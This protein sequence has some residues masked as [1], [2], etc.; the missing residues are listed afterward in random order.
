MNIQEIIKLLNQNLP[1]IL[2]TDTVYGLFIKKTAENA[3]TLYQIKN[4]DYSKKLVIYTNDWQYVNAPVTIVKHKQGYRY[5][6][7]LSEII[8]NVGE[9]WGTSANISN[10]Y[11]VTQVSQ[12]KLKLPVYEYD[13]LCL[14][15]EST[16]FNIDTNEIYRQGLYFI[17]TDFYTL[18]NQQSEIT[19]SF[20]RNYYSYK[21]NN[22]INLL[23]NHRNLC[24][25]D[26]YYTQ[27]LIKQY[28]N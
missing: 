27:Y 21:N 26:D 14:G 8:S 22:D 5:V 18:Y 3:E 13:N 23:N 12:I 1:V 17:N 28:L 7:F 25:T 2:P 9:L 16:V 10:Q 6:P 24:P 20:I 15:Y 19:K 4:R 11:S